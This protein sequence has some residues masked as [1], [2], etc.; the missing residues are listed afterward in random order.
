[1]NFH[2][3]NFLQGGGSGEFIQVGLGDLFS[4]MNLLARSKKVEK[5]SKT[6]DKPQ[7]KILTLFYP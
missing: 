3:R 2:V 7:I 5:C 4:T 1:M 6:H